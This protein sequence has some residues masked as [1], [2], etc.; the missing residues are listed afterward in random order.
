MWQIDNSASEVD[1]R[2]GSTRSCDS[3][4]MLNGNWSPGRDKVLTDLRRIKDKGK[5]R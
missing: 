5:G 3:D 4:T 1:T 2:P